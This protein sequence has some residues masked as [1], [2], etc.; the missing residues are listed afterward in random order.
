MSACEHDIVSKM[1]GRTRLRRV[2]D[3]RN[4]DLFK[5]N[6]YYTYFSQLYGNNGG[7]RFEIFLIDFTRAT[8]NV[9]ENRLN[10]C[11][12]VFEYHACFIRRISI[13]HEYLLTY[14]YMIITAR[15]V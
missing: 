3:H 5:L 8:L 11:D 10:R 14:T 15:V 6:I 1:Y 2:Y 13:S 12:K 9:F 7:Y 4:K